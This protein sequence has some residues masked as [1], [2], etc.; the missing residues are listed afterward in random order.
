MAVWQIIL[1]R[2]FAAMLVAAVGA[3]I[4]VSMK[5]L[6]HFALC[7]LISIAAGALLSV[8]LFEIL[9]EAYQMTGIIEIVIGFI[10]GYALF[11][12]VSKYIY[13]ICPACAA[14]HTEERFLAVNYLMIAAISLHS[15]MDGI[16][17]AVSAQ[18]GNETASIAIL[19]AVS[20]H[21]LPEGLALASVARGAGYSR[22]KAFAVAIGIESTTLIGGLVADAI[23]HYYN[24]LGYFA[25]FAAYAVLF[26]L[27]SVALL[28]VKDGIQNPAAQAS[29]AI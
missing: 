9:P 23:N 21:K 28:W 20:I 5:K 3:L 19:L 27:S 15:M 8:T 10:T 7:A 13:H 6:S 4:A 1:A 25:I 16:G 12:L 2:A 18:T 29:Q 24:G 14:T 17:V 22:R 26:A 11:F